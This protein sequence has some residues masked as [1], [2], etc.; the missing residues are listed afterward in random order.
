[1]IPCTLGGRYQPPEACQV[2]PP[3]RK[4]AAPRGPRG[5]RSIFCPPRPL[6]LA[7]ATAVLGA[8]RLTCG[9]DEHVSAKSIDL[10]VRLERLLFG[11]LS[12]SYEIPR[13]ALGAEVSRLLQTLLQKFQEGLEALRLLACTWTFRLCFANSSIWWQSWGQLSDLLEKTAEKMVAVGYDIFETYGVHASLVRIP[14]PV[15]VQAGR[16]AIL[17]MLLGYSSCQAVLL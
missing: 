12:R 6:P 10:E 17:E 16:N 3:S 4:T 14:K 11:M 5:A 7:S 9:P 13:G 8:D 2:L 15:A 1:M